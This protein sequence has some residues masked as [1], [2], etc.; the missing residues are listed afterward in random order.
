MQIKLMESRKG[1]DSMYVVVEI[2][3]SAKWGWFMPEDMRGTHEEVP[4]VVSPHKLDLE[5]R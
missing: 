2:R 3:I 5:L 4:D 1:Q